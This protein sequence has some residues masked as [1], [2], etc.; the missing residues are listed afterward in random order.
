MGFA[1]SK[2]AACEI[3]GGDM[4]A[5]RRLPSHAPLHLLAERRGTRP[6]GA[7]PQSPKVGGRTRG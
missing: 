7:A 6:V 2:D 5:E 3:C 4:V 1:A